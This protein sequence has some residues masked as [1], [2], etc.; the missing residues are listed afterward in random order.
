MKTKVLAA[1]GEDGLRRPAAVNAALAASDRVKFAFTLPQAVL[2]RTRV[3]AN[4]CR[5]H[6]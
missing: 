3:A 6:H 4:V 1:I 2:A 5:H